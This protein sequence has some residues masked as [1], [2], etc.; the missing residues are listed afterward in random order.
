MQAPAV[1]TYEVQEHEQ[2]SGIPRVYEPIPDPMLTHQFLMG[3]PLPTPV[4][5]NLA[6]GIPDA[7]TWQGNQLCI[8][9]F[10]KNFRPRASF[11]GNFYNSIY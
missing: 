4:S 6:V 8:A 3:Q 5:I 1:F 10:T 9:F 2:P 11:V 7:L